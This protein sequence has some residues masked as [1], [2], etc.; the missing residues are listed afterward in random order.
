MNVFVFDIETIPDVNA[1][2]ALYDL[3]DLDDENI[4]NALL[5]MRREEA[6]GSE[7]L[8]H[9]MHQIV[10]ISAVLRTPTQLK[11]WSLGEENSS[12]KELLQR[13]FAGIEKFSPTLIT[14]NGSGFDLPVIHYRAL[15]HGICSSRYWE[16][17]DMDSQFKWNNYLN[18]YHDRHTDLM[19]TL[20]GFQARATAPLDKIAVMLG[21]PGKLGESG[22]K[23]WSYFNAGRIDR[24]RNYCETDVL[25]TYL[26]YLRYQLIRGRLSEIDYLAECNVLRDLLISENKTH[27]NEFVHAWKNDDRN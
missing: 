7:F 19:D 3:S 6:A 2:K 5:K 1:G 26:I 20:S 25:N 14:W 27:F 18:R 17:G 11:V 22:E 16:T 13:F 15:I 24:I 10:C 21:L 8:P 12:E 23:V 9:Y 4:V